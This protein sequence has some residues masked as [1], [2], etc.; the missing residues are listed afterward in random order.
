MMSKEAVSAHLLPSMSL[1][2]ISASSKAVAVLVMWYSDL[3]LLYV[4]WNVT[5]SQDNPQ[6]HIR[7]I[8]VSA[9][10]KTS[11]PPFPRKPVIITAPERPSM[12]YVLMCSTPESG[13][14]HDHRTHAYGPSGVHAQK[15]KG[16]SS[17]PSDLPSSPLTHRSFP[18]T[19]LVARDTKHPL[20]RQVAAPLKG[21]RSLAWLVL[22]MDLTLGVSPPSPA[23]A[24]PIVEVF[25]LC[26]ILYSGRETNTEGFFVSWIIGPYSLSGDGE[27]RCAMSGDRPGFRRAQKPGR[28]CRWVSPEA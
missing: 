14:R 13:S 4:S 10:K 8:D 21:D 2:S 18:I 11:I 27:F 19:S 28:C 15:V 24:L 16:Q 25:W 17:Q 20:P 3:F 5:K 6:E 23:A 22:T 9:M 7:S 1:P 26:Q 12:R